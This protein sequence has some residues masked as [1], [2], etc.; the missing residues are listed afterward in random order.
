MG[1]TFATT[2]DGDYY[3]DFEV[4]HRKGGVLFLHQTRYTNEVLKW[5]P[6]IDCNPVST[7]V[8][9]HVHCPYSQILYMQCTDFSSL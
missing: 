2:G 5:F 9:P 7:P 4:I 6:M 1:T 8:G 3:V